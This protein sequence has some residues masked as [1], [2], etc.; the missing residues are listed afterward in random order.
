[1]ISGSRAALLNPNRIPIVK[2][3]KFY[4]RPLH[5]GPASDR[6]VRGR[7]ADPS[8]HQEQHDW[9][10]ERDLRPQRKEVSTDCLH[11]L[12]HVFRVVRGVHVCVFLLKR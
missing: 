3:A 2:L 11:E 9:L 10:Q 4:V 1:M 7:Y 5:D 12:R 6:V 8:H